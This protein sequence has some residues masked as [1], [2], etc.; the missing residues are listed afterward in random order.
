[1]L[2][3]A[4]LASDV[5]PGPGINVRNLKSAVTTFVAG[6]LTRAERRVDRHHVQTGIV[7]SAVGGQIDDSNVITWGR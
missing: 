4:A 6:H 2:T 5:G 1:M 3:A 7:R